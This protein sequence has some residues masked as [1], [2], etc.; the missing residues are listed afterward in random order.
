MDTFFNGLESVYSNRH[1]KAEQRAI[2]ENAIALNEQFM[3]ELE[4]LKEECRENGIE[5]NTLTYE[6]RMEHLY[7][8]YQMDE[9]HT[10]EAAENR[11]T[12]ELERE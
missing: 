10:G 1:K 11:E 7:E 12:D 4:A 5:E 8:K 2:A 9:I 3:R 6:L